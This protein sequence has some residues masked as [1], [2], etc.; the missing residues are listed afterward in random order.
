MNVQNRKPRVAIL[1]RS[2]GTAS[3]APFKVLE[4]AGIP[5]TI[6]HNQEPQ[7]TEHI[8]EI[9]GD[10]DAVIC[11][12]DVMDRYVFDRCP[13]LKIISKH[14]VGLD[15]IDQKLAEERGI[16]VCCTPSANFETVA[17]FAMTLIL[18][19]QRDLRSNIIMTKTPSWNK[20]ALTHDLFRA[21]VGIMGYGRI[22]RAVAERLCGFQARILVYDP[23]LDASKISTPNTKLVSMDEV[24]SQSDI[25]SLHLPLTDS[26]KN[27]MNRDAFAKMKQGASIVNTSRGAIMDYRALY[28]ALRSGKLRSAAV[29]V[30]PQEPPVNEPLLELPN[31]IAT[32][33]IATYTVESNDRMGIAAAKNIVDFFGS[34]I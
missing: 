6:V 7:N 8:A 28:D 23:Y 2:F 30:Y 21:T 11:G 16:F 22:G 18:A 13:N 5:Y 9:V 34:K 32:P 29:D 17:D 25:I 3:H 26:T 1:S 12:S 15:S 20:P 27:I 24:L 31:V 14:G 10:A 33:H 19:L 4:S